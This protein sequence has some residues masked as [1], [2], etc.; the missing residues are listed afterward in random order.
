MSFPE[1]GHLIFLIMNFKLTNLSAINQKY[2]KTMEQLKGSIWEVCANSCGCSG[3]C[4]SN[5]MRS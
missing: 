3:D 2:G 1:I 4:G 5:W